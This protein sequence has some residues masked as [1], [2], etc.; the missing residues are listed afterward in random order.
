M[1]VLSDGVVRLRPFVPADADA[2]LS[3]WRDPEIRKRNTVPDL[4]SEA[5]LAWVA[6]RAALAT[7]GRAW[8]WAITD[9]ATSQLAG[10][11]SIREINWTD[12]RALSAA[13][14]APA[15]RGRRFSPRSLRLAAGHAFANGIARIQVDCEADN[16]ASIRSA[17]A[18]GARHEGT[19]RDYWITNAGLRANVE[20]FSLLPADLATALPL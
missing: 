18:A 1:P 6:D 7:A 10:R 19:L 13:W 14:V 11:R 15:F 4:S 20:T 5:A 16:A 3:I 2:L 17:L 8:E 9:A 12:G